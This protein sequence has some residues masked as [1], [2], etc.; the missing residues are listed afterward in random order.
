[1]TKKP[2]IFIPC[3]DL[4]EYQLLP[5]ALLLLLDTVGKG[6]NAPDSTEHKQQLGVF[7]ADWNA[8][9][10]EHQE[11]FASRMAQTLLHGVK[12]EHMKAQVA[13]IAYQNS[14]SRIRSTNHAAN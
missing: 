6:Q 9:D 2:A 10:K 4:I 14:L 12:L 8:L 11:E 13:D 3:H 7:L 5:C 1:M